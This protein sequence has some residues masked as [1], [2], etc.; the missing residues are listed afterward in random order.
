MMACAAEPSDNTMV[1]PVSMVGRNDVNRNLRVFQISIGEI[2]LDQ[3]AQ[4]M[5][6]DEKITPNQKTQHCTP[7]HR[8]NVAPAQSAPDRLQALDA[9][10]RGI[11]GVIGAVE[12]ADAGADNHIRG[13][14]V[15][16]E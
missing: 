13:N 6:L 10:E 3:H 7:A 5:R 15:C 4:A 14:A 8:K 16:R 9:F 12:R 1:P 11:T 2:V